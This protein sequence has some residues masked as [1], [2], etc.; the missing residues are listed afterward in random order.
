MHNNFYLFRRQIEEIA[1]PVREATISDVFV[2][3]KTD[4]VFELTK[5]GE[6]PLYLVFIMEV[7]TPAVLLEN[8]IDRK[9]SRSYIF[10]ELKNQ[11]IRN[12]AIRPYDKHILI[13][14]DSCHL[15]A[16]FYGR[17][18][19]LIIGRPDGRYINAFRKPVITTESSKSTALDLASSYE[20]KF[21]DLPNSIDS[22][23]QLYFIQNRFAAINRTLFNEIRFRLEQ[24]IKPL[25]T[26]LQEISRDLRTG[27]VYLYFK[28]DTVARLS[29]IRLFHLEA[30]E[31]VHF[32]TSETVN[33]LWLAF[34]YKRRFRQQFDKLY[35]KCRQA[36]DKRAEQL[37][38]AL[39]KTEELS[40]LEKRKR[41]AEIKGNL[42]LT[43]M[44]QIPAGS[45]RVE[46]DN[47]YGQEPQKIVIK[48]NPAKSVSEN[49]QRY[50][51][52]FKDIRQKAAVQSI[53]K[54]TFMAELKEIRMLQ[55]KLQA[56]DRMP[57]LQALY[58]DCLNR[59][60]I[61]PSRPRQ[62]SD[63]SSPYSF[64]RIHID[65]DWEVFIGKSGLQNDR[66]TFEVA[67]KWDIWLHAQGV[68]GA[69]VILRVPDRNKKPPKRIIEQAAA[70]AAANSKARHSGTVPVVY[71]EVRYVQRVRK[72][73]PGTVTLRNE[74][75]IFVTPLKLNG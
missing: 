46:L 19:N 35:Q 32:K 37:Q 61:Q 2:L 27:T 23:Q 64:S 60:L 30:Q 72:A 44:N 7:Q 75:I 53:K 26:I 62:K 28:A 8:R 54:E 43:F 59:H 52:K 65:K 5:T 9:T 42:L 13:E 16:V 6:S 31:K 41:E 17:Q 29:L 67:R 63:D 21:S 10:S 22:E 68:S 18:F 4:I 25:K 71:T 34:V 50:F 1:S 3:N 39:Q 24:E 58:K 51:N 56:C 36:L 55:Q 45:S 40:D 49:A 66:L 14:L 69:H 57:K 20:D 12:I 33:E 11:K 38:K 74:Q 48:L 15:E 70:I 73:K 47:V